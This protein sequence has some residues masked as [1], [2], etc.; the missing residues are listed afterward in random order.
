MKNANNNNNSSSRSSYGEKKMNNLK[1][2][3][4]ISS[5]V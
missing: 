3:A 5:L 1:N 2:K 4:I